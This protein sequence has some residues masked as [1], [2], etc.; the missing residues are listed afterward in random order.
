MYHFSYK[1][2][3]LANFA[4]MADLKDYVTRCQEEILSELE[5]KGIDLEDVLT[6]IFNKD[7]S[8]YISSVIGYFHYGFRT[9]SIIHP[10]RKCRLTV[11]EAV[12]MY[13]TDYKVLNLNNH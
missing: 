4:T 2:N 12:R 3:S 6:Y 1:G 7:K 9:I 11:E 8:K 10:T 5:K 13:F